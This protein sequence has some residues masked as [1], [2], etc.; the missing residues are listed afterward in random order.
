MSMFVSPSELPNS[1]ASTL[2]AA[3]N[4]AA[5]S[6]NSWSSLNKEPEPEREPEI[7]DANEQEQI[8][9]LNKT[10]S[11]HIADATAHVFSSTTTVQGSCRYV[12]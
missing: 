11:Q 7:V 5:S 12:F 8:E 4:T 9:R 10:M 6:S 2:I 1:T 3:S